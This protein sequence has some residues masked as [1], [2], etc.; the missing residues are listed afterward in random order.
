MSNTRIIPVVL[1]ACLAT[2]ACTTA[3]LA[4]PTPLRDDRMSVER[5][6][7]FFHK[8]KM[9]FGPYQA[10]GID[11]SWTSSSGW[12]INGSGEKSSKQKYQFRFLAGAGAPDEV[13][14]S[15]H[16][17]QDSVDLG[18]LTLKENDLGLGCAFRTADGRPAG[19]LQMRAV[20]QVTHTGWVQ[21]EGMTLEVASTHDLENSSMDAYEIVGYEL[22]LQGHVVGAV[23]VINGGAV[24]IDRSAPA[25]IQRA[26]AIAAASLLLFEDITEG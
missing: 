6:G 21:A 24:W 10:S 19:Q 8:S 23:Q 1:T 5:S 13:R 3:R 9:A 18:L 22:R 15:T 12:S 11:R 4:V 26:A 25:Q 17:G 14:C 7:G 20:D 2:A 16:F